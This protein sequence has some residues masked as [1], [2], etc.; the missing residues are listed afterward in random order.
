MQGKVFISVCSLSIRSDYI[1]A[2]NDVTHPKEFDVINCNE[3]EPAVRVSK[4][5]KVW[6]EKKRNK[7]QL[8]SK[9][10]F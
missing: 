10:I 9:W 7:R 4:Q 5:A 3:Q 8:E 6:G 2:E 1:I